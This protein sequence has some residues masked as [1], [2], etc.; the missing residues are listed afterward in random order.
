MTV[1]ELEV[2]GLYILRVDSAIG[3]EEWSYTGECMPANPEGYI[4]CFEGKAFNSGYQWFSEEDIKQFEFTGEID[5]WRK[6]N[7]VS[8]K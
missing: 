3:Y 5:Y 6:F 1:E 2:G 4:Y 8:K 7:Y